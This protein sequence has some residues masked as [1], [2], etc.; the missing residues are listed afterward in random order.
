VYNS[1]PLKNLVG[2]NSSGDDKKVAAGFEPGTKSLEELSSM[3]KRAE[4]LV[5]KHR[6][7]VPR[8]LRCEEPGVIIVLARGS[9]GIFGVGFVRGFLGQQNDCL[10]GTER[11]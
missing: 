5:K 6:E 8:L 9:S 2:K 11:G 7:A 10:R 3:G 4:L 1:G